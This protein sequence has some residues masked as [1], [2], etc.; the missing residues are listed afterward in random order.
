M[1]RM[2]KRENVLM[3][4]VVLN[5][6]ILLSML[7]GA[8]QVWKMVKPLVPQAQA[9]LS[10]VDQAIADTQGLRDIVSDVGL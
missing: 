2:L 8:W 4:L 3:L 7:L 9:T 1:V 5:T 6:L 10:G